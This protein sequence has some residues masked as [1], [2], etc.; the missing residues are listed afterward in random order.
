MNLSEAIERANDRARDLH[1]LHLKSDERSRLAAALFAIAQQHHSAILLLLSNKQ[2]IEASAFSLLRPL[3]EVTVRGGWVLRCASDTELK[4]VIE[5]TQKQIKMPRI[6]SALEKALKESSGR[7]IKVKS[8]YDNH[9]EPLSAYTHGYEQQVQRW[10]ATKDIE[11]SYSALEVEE[12]ISRSDQI[13]NL[14]YIFTKSL[15]VADA[16]V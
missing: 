15:G 12:L 11:P 7:D 16:S 10:L 14:A 4:N 13:A 6:F 8:L 3:I 9:W 2:P 1:G 5:G